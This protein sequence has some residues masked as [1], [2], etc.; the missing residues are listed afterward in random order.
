MMKRDSFYRAI[1]KD[2]NDPSN[3]FRIKA[4]VPSVYGVNFI[5]DWIRCAFVEGT[6][7][8]SVGDI[9][10]VMFEDG[11]IDYPIWSFGQFIEGKVEEEFKGKYDKIRLLKSK[12]GSKV[13]IDDEEDIITIKHHKGS[14]I[15]ITSD[16]VEINGN[17]QKAVKGDELNNLLSDL[18]TTLYTA[19]IITPAGNGVFDPSFLAKINTLKAKIESSVIL[20]NKVK[21]S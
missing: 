15:K 2:V 5:T 8:P 21:L 17:T 19:T 3:N 14:L 6:K 12:A 10:Y 1:V 18:L 11:D 16:A 13:L 20:S 9:V 4:V 7:L